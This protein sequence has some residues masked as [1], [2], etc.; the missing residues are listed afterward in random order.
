ML[1]LMRGIASD[2]QFHLGT[3]IPGLGGG[4]NLMFKYSLVKDGEIAADK[5]S[6]MV[7]YRLN[8]NKMKNLKKSRQLTFSKTTT[9]NSVYRRGR[10]VYG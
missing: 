7:T 9:E 6:D 8:I 3:E 1:F 4:G 2:Y 10:K 5:A